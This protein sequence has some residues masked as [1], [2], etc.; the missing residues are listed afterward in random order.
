MRAILGIICILSV[1]CLTACGGRFREVHYFATVNKTTQQP[2]NFFRLSVKGAADATNAR[3]IAGFYDERAVDIF[4]N[5]TNNGRGTATDNP[6]GEV[7]SLFDVALC[8]SVATATECAAKRSAQLEVVPVGGTSSTLDHGAFVMI[9]SSNAD[10]I[11]KTIGSLAD[12]EAALSSTLFLL[13]RDQIASSAKVKAVAAVAGAQR[14][15]A[16]AEIAT[17]LTAAAAVTDTAQAGIDKRTELYLAAVRAAA[18]ASGS[19]MPI[20]NIDEAR[21]WLRTANAGGRP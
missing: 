1:T 5:Q 3:Y 18:R 21:E 15:A 14:D 16:N 10:A 7:R 20:G 6:R 9:M 2:V 17:L 13:N 8:A 11:A 19:N 4:L 12:N